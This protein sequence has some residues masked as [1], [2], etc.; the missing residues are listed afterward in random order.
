LAGF[1]VL[2]GNMATQDIVTSF[3]LLGWF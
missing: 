2:D 1:D 3:V